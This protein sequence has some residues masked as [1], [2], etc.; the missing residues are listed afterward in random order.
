MMPTVKD[1]VM[2]LEQFAP[3]QLAEPWDKVGL[4]IGSQA[5]TV[6]RILVA[7]ELTEAVVSEAV[8]QHIDLIIL[9]HPAIFAAL[10]SLCT[11]DERI[12]LYATLLRHQIAVYVA[13]TN[14]DAASGGMN[15]WVAQRLGLQQVAP[16]TDAEGAP[17]IGRIG[18]LAQPMPLVHYAEHVKQ[19]FDLAAVRLVTTD[20]QQLVRRV[21]VVA[22]GGISYYPLALAQRA[23]VFVTGD[24]RFH[25]A[26]ELLAKGLSCIDPGH[27]IERICQPHLVA[28]LSQWADAAGWDITVQ[29]TI[30]V[31]DPFQ[32]V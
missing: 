18:L 9:H 20:K 10:D 8:T 16:L 2:Q 31:L 19:A 24:V 13:H 23:D 17:A 3:P 12:H 5:A 1:I 21:A 27:A 6:R 11:D 26:H 30:A 29:E 4:Q 28:L 14:L 32:F 7:L 15:D 25:P 22:G